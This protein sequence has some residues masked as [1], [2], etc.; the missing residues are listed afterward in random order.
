MLLECPQKPGIVL[1]VTELLKDQ[2]C[3][4]TN[5]DAQT[6]LKGEGKERVIWFRLEVI[7]EITT[8]TDPALVEEQLRWWTASQQMDVDLIFDSSRTDR[9]Q[10]L[11]Q[12]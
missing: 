6:Y 12:A 2:G 10:P 7:I 5:M 8:G 4:I 3:A 1:A 9:F 11:E